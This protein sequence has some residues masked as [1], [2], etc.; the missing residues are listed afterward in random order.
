MADLTGESNGGVLR[1]DFDRR[2]MLQFRGSVVTSD[3][4][5]LPYRELDDVLGLSV[6]AG[7]MLADART[8]KNGRHAL[9]GLLRRSAFGRLAGYEDL[10]DAERLRH[11]PA[12]R[13]IV[14]GKAALNAAAS[15]SQMGRFETKWLVRE[16]NLLALA[17]LPALGMTLACPDAR[18]QDGPSSQLANTRRSEQFMDATEGYLADVGL[19]VSDELQSCQ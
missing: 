15:P 8:G 4:G 18:Q 3:G 7:E 16:K 14:G 17:N 13:W 9:V 5:L 11:D 19:G 12:M 6:T 10:N 2:L 1:L